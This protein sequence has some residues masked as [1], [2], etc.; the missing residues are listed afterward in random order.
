MVAPRRRA[1]RRPLSAYEPIRRRDGAEAAERQQRRP[2]HRGWL[3][4]EGV[5]VEFDVGARS[6]DIIE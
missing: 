1:N 3:N 6:T 5:E 2:A 4:R